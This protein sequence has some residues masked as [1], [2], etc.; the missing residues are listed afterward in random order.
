MV[1]AELAVGVPGD[2][3]Q[4]QVALDVAGDAG[5]VEKRLRQPPRSP[6]HRRADQPHRAS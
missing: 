4:E 3:A 2:P 1:A 5:L 6:G